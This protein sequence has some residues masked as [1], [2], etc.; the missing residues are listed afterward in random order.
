MA[1][2]ALLCFVS[3]SGHVV[4]PRSE[5]I[6][7]LAVENVNQ[8][9][10]NLP[11]SITDDIPVFSASGLS[12][13]LHTEMFETQEDGTVV[14]TKSIRTIRPYFLNPTLLQQAIHTLSAHQVEAS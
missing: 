4:V 3:L 13:N 6:E 12:L 5:D 1:P 7:S 14:S 10:C 11:P 2:R 9:M 8:S